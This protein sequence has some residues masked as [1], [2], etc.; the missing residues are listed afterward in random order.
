M[1]E[2]LSGILGTPPVSLAVVF[3]VANSLGPVTMIS[4]GFINDK[5]GPR[6]LVFAGGLLFSCGMF[7][8]GF[9][10]SVK[11]LVITY[12]VCGGLSMGLVYGSAVSNSVKF[13][14]DKRGF[15]GGIAAASYGISSILVPPAANALIQTAGVTAAF[16]II[17]IAAA[18]IISVSSLFIQRCPPEFTPDGW[19]PAQQDSPSAQK[20]KN[21]K[22]MLLDPVCYLMLA[23]LCCGAFPGLMVISQTSPI[24]QRSVGMSAI[25]ATGAVSML[26]FFNTGGRVIA[27]FI[28]DKLGIIKTLAGIFSAS[29][30]GLALLFFSGAGDVITFYMG[31]AFVGLSFGSIIG[32]FPG[33][34]AAQFGSK[35][36]SVNFGIMYVGFAF[37]GYFGPAIMSAV[38]IKSGNYRPT[39]LI[40]AALSAAGIILSVIFGAKTYRISRSHDKKQK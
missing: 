11:M 28:S 34:T 5:L 4:G 33:L 27:G 31:V 20:E 36:N 9:A 23:M 26:A 32:T 12:G 10:S 16:K 19:T 13:F 18:V 21:W 17:G 3:S 7:F 24:A 25:A 8:S 22:A 30:I 29:I 6:A 38:Y 37:A 40:A 35:N 15:A 39:F 2:H 14:P 1:A